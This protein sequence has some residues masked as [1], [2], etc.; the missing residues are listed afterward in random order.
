[1]ADYYTQLVVQQTI[2]SALIS[3][4]EQLLLREMLEHE[5]IDGEMYFFASE[6]VCDFPSVSRRELIE[7]L[8]A[9]PQRSRLKTFVSE[10]LARHP[11]DC[12]HIDLDFSASVYGSDAYLIILQ[13]IVRRA[14]AQLPYLTIVGSY[15]CSKMRPDGFGGMCIT[16]TPSAIRYWSTYDVLERFTARFE[17]T[18]AAKLPPSAQPQHREAASP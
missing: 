11:D 12:P 16:I 2:P 14:K 15:T 1:M 4:F 9:S 3:P 10:Q 18:R 17:K 13:D 6:Q 7:A 8:A 5:Q